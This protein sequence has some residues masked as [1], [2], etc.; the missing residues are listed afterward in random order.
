MKLNHNFQLF[1]LE[2]VYF[3]IQRLSNSLKQTKQI[4]KKKIQIQKTNPNLNIHYL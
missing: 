2:S 1:I 3:I 4:Q